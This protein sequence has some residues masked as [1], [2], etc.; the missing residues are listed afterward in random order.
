MR[1]AAPERPAPVPSARTEP[2]RLQPTAGSGRTLLLVLFVLLTMAAVLVGVFLVRSPRS[3]G[4]QSPDPVPLGSS[5]G[6]LTSREGVLAGP[7]VSE[8]TLGSK[9]VR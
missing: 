3:D 5:T 9:I 1:R 6:T 7:A 2:L 8:R 4:R